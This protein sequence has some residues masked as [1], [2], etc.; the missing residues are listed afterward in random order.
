MLFMLE[1]KYVWMADFFLHLKLKQKLMKH[2]NLN[3]A[4]K[5]I[6]DI[7]SFTYLWTQ[8]WVMVWTEYIYSWVGG[9]IDYFDFDFLKKEQQIF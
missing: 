8:T 2:L 5:V 3:M 4:F 7:F 1:V 6:L 9:G